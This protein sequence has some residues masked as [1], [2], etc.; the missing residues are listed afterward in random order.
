MLE[1]CWNN[2]GMMLEDAGMMLGAMLERCLND[3][4]TNVLERS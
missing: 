3:A 1:R 4:A 2:A